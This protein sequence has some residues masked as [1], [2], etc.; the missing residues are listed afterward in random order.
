MSTGPTSA[1]WIV[2]GGVAAGWGGAEGE[3]GP[4]DIAASY[5]RVS[6]A[7]RS[8]LIPALLFLPVSLAP[9]R[10]ACCWSVQVVRRPRPRETRGI[11]AARCLPQA[12]LSPDDLVQ[13]DH[14]ACPP[15]HGP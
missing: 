3:V 5:H 11:R 4:V 10:G 6:H 15:H 8:D 14:A 9:L 2:G 7:V 13:V 1:S 12:K